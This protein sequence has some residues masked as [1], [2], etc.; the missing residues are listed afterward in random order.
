MSF[1]NLFC[2]P[3]PCPGHSSLSKK[4]K[5][6][7]KLQRLRTT[8]SPVLFPL[9]FVCSE[10]NKKRHSLWADTTKSSTCQNTTTVTIPTSTTLPYES[11]SE[12]NL[13]ANAAWFI[14][15]FL[16][17]CRH[18]NPVLNLLLFVSPLF[19]SPNFRNFFM[20]IDHAIHNFRK[21]KT[22]PSSFLDLRAVVLPCFACRD[23]LFSKTGHSESTFVKNMI[24]KYFQPKRLMRGENWAGQILP[25]VS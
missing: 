22:F 3:L 7:K 2:C 10:T 1:Y 24:L 4:K 19:T 15:F 16:L 9:L 25:L 13:I 20:H 5:K 6:K 11:T 12:R 8:D 14:K 21:P 17:P 23:G 18:I